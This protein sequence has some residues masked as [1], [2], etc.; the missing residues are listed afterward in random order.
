MRRFTASVAILCMAAALGAQGAPGGSVSSGEGSETTSSALAEATSPASVDRRPSDLIARFGVQVVVNRDQS[1]PIV[2]GPSPVVVVPGVAMVLPL[3]ERL[4][5]V[6][7][8][9]FYSAYYD[10]AN[11][12]AVPIG[13]EGRSASVAALILDLPLAWDIKLPR[14]ENA[15]ALG[16]GASSAQQKI[17]VQGGVALLARAAFLAEGLLPAEQEAA[18][19]TLGPISSYMWAKGRFFYPSLGL[20]YSYELADWVSFGVSARVMIP[21][22]NL[23]TGEGLPFADALHA[24]GG[25]WVSFTD[26]WRRLGKKKPAESS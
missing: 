24:G 22:F 16:S 23:W 14:V 20:G 13:V 2:S 5:L 10:W 9:E 19:A 3:G 17:I 4:S 26:F 25:I 12:R 7:G 18:R 6:P 8:L 21:V 15:A 11:D 1:V